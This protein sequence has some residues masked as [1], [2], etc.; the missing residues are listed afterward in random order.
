[1]SENEVSKERIEACLKACENF[2]TEGLQKGIIEQIFERAYERISCWEDIEGIY[3]Y[4]QGDLKDWVLEE[5][6]AD[7]TTHEDDLFME[8]TT[9]IKLSDILG[10]I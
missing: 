4:L 7:Y 3:Q 2:T 1:M 5:L 9:P 8:E 6:D 10:Y